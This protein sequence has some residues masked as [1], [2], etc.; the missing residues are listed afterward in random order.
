MKFR[1]ALRGEV[2]E[3]LRITDTSRNFVAAQSD[4]ARDFYTG[5]K[6]QKTADLSVVLTSKFELVI[7]LQTARTLAFAI[8]P[9]LLAIADEIIE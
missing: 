8:P 9:S 7:N 5:R 4:A 6:G 2:G 1:L 3:Q